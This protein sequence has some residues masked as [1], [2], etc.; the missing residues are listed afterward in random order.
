MNVNLTSIASGIVLA[1]LCLAGCTQPNDYVAPPPPQVTVALPIE[2]PVQEYFITT[3]QT[4]AAATVELR[5]MVEGYLEE[6]KFED[7]DVVE[8]DQL[9]FVIEKEPFEIAVR[10]AQA[11]LDK[12][13]AQLALADQQLTRA[14]ALAAEEATPVSNLDIRQAEHAAAVA[15]VEAAQAALADA[16]LNRDYTEIR[17]PF[18]GRIGRHLVDKGNLVQAEITLLA[19]IEAVDPM[20]AYFA[21]SD[22]DLLRFRELQRSGKM[23]LDAEQIPIELALGDRGEFEFEGRLDFREFGIQSTTGTTMFRAR[24]DNPSAGLIPG[25]FVRVRMKV[26]EP[27]PMLLVDERALA[28]DQRGEYLTVV[29]AD[30]VVMHRVVE[31]GDRQGSLRA[32]RAGLRADDWVVVNGLQRARPGVTVVPDRK[33]LE[34]DEEGVIVYGDPE[35]EA[36]A[37]QTDEEATAEGSVAGEETTSAE[38]EPPAP[39]DAAEATPEATTE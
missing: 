22:S 1:M 8:E 15:D 20:H 26:G 35:E 2:R 36:P 17:A 16:E 6:V 14:T 24:F 19:T 28:A 18:A 5:A 30:N 23:E 27:A 29:N 3:G 21:V 33:V 11:D 34:V 9:L 39:T 25:M 32:I 37:D 12:A 10:T 38:M 31:L 13:E 4:Q 7:G